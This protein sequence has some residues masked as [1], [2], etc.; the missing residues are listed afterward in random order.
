MK[1]PTPEELLSF[2]DGSADTETRE[3]VLDAVD[4]WPEVAE[5]LRSLVAGHEAATAYAE[6]HGAPAVRAPAATGGRRV[7]AW[8]IPLTAAATLALAIPSTVRLAA[9]RPT[10]PPPDAAASGEPLTPEPS[11]VVVL[12]G[13]W[14]DALEIDRDETERRAAEYWAWTSRLAEAG[15]LVAAGDLRWEPGLAVEPSGPSARPATDLSDP[16]F[17]VGMITIRVA[18][19]EE[20]AALAGECPHLRYGGSVSVRRVGRGFV[21]VPGMDDWSD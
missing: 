12:Q 13:R 17:L 3:R 16:G 7:P 15:H 18:T 10:V 2:V 11:F 8:W 6:E 9:G 5:A 14:P 4:R 20:A 1:R 19:Y 21:T